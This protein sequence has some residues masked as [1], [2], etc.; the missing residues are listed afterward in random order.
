MYGHTLKAVCPALG[1]TAFSPQ[2]V[3]WL[4][5]F[6]C[7]AFCSERAVIPWGMMMMRLMLQGGWRKEIWFWMLMGRTWRA[8]RMTGILF[9]FLI[10]CSSFSMRFSKSTCW[11]FIIVIMTTIKLHGFSG[12]RDT[13]VKVYMLIIYIPYKDKAWCHP[14]GQRCSVHMLIINY[15]DDNSNAQWHCWGETTPS[16]KTA[17]W[18]L[19]LYVSIRNLARICIHRS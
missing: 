16:L 12:E 5:L 9:W 18:N 11:L 15:H 1:T 19:S 2:T 3:G 7:A 4:L 8:S 13:Q 10:Y 14:W 17:V 6:V